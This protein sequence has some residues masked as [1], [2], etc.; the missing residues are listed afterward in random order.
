MRF[1]KNKLGTKMELVESKT[2]YIHIPRG[3]SKPQ[4]LRQYVEKLL[5]Q[6]KTVK[7]VDYSKKGE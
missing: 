3:Y 5:A 1:F 2:V 6:G 7:I 4:A